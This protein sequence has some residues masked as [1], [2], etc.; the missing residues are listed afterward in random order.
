MHA[1]TAGDPGIV[2]AF[3]DARNFHELRVDPYYRRLAERAPQSAS[4]AGTMI[5]QLP[6]RRECLVHADYSPKNVLVAGERI[7]LVDYETV[8][9]GDPAFDLGFFLSHLLLKGI[10]HHTR[11]GIFARLAE[12]FWQAYAAGISQQPALANFAEQLPPRVMPHLALCMWARIDGTSKIDYLDEA[13]HNT[14][15]TFCLGL[16]SDPPRQWTGATERLGNVLANQPLAQPAAATAAPFVHAP[17]AATRTEATRIERIHAR[18]VLDSRGRPTVEVEVHC[19]HGAK[20]LAIVPSGA[21]TGAHEA[22][23]L[24]D[25]DPARYD[26]LGVQRAVANV[27]EHLAGAVRGMSAVDQQALDRALCELDGTERKSRLGA[28][29]LLGVSL[30]AARAAAAARGI[31]VARHLADLWR[32]QPGQPARGTLRSGPPAS[33]GHAPALP[34]PMVNMISG[35][36]HAGRQLDIQDFLALPV[37]APSYGQALEWVARIHGRLSRLLVDAGMEGVLV[38]DEGGF[39]PRLER[40]EQALELL[41]R[42]IEAAGLRPG[43][44]VALGLDVASTHFHARGRYAMAAEK[45]VFEPAEL[46]EMLAQWVGR[47]P[48]I[49]IEDGAAEDDWHGWRLLTEALGRN[50]QLIGD[51]LFATN[52]SR[53][54]LGVER[55][56]ANAVLIKLNQIG[57]LSETLAA[58][59][60]ALDHGYWPVISARSGETEDSTIADLAVATGAGQIKIGSVARGERLAKYN[61]LL[62]LEEEWGREAPYLGGAIFASLG[63]A[64]VRTG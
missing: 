31:E 58:M 2:R 28:N 37:G 44:D 46:V 48:I 18:E 17:G 56:V 45:R 60:F 39:G 34:L 49:S 53:L 19:R 3:G 20:G 41:V 24:R 1:A 42:A 26:G 10:L 4:F 36:M 21:S 14:V 38:G 23:E 30:A 11:F 59:H 50:V 9:Y 7:I 47:Y 5:E 15:R 61:Q 52:I 57:T 13:W 62:R 54:R 8:H 16:L 63:G 35:G 40:H 12:A 6:L 29:A 64:A 32:E 43:D 55:G 25:A 22:H 51:D 33:L 27:N